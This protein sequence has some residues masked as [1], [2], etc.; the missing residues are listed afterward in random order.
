MNQRLNPVADR[1]PGST[2]GKSF[3]LCY[4]YVLGLAQNF[5]MEK[6]KVNQ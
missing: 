6:W 5:A 4:H 2:L 1:P 3:A